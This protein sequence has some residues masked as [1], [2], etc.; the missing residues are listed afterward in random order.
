MVIVIVVEGGE[1]K[2]RR[3]TIIIPFTFNNCGKRTKCFSLLSSNPTNT[4]SLLNATFSKYLITL[5]T[6]TYGE[7]PQARQKS[8]CP[9]HSLQLIHSS[10]ITFSRRLLRKLSYFHIQL[11]V[12]E[13]RNPQLFSGSCWWS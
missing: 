11:R 5:Q 8:I 6:D 4:L 1:G 10:Q 7:G 2:A 3:R 13:Y 12:T 9:T